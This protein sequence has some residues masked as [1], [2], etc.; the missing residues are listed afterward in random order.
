LR[1]QCG[2]GEPAD[3]TAHDNNFAIHS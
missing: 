2:D 1:E 3:A